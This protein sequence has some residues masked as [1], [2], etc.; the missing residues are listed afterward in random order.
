MSHASQARG[1][2]SEDSWEELLLDAD[3]KLTEAGSE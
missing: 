2:K 1:C 3:I